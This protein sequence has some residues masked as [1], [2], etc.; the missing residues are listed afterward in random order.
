MYATTIAHDRNS[1]R[2]LSPSRLGFS[3][4]GLSWVLNGYTLAF[5]G[6]LLLGGRLGD[7]YGRLR[8]FQIGLTLFT[9]ASFAGGLA[10]TADLLVAGSAPA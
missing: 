3:P 7:V 1:P 2:P 6:L 5:G 9:L 4:A 8:V 10:P